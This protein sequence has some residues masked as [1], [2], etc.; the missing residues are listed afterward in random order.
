MSGAF[1]FNRPTDS[2]Q[3]GVS[4]KRTKVNSRIET[5]QSSSQA[6]SFRLVFLALLA[7]STRLLMRVIR[8]KLA[9]ALHR[10]GLTFPGCVNRSALHL[11]Q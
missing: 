10:L 6:A 11:L 9:L 4:L 2:R 1:T 8:P 7:T 5:G 3:L